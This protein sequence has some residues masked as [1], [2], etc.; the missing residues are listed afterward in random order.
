MENEKF[1]E[2]GSLEGSVKI[3]GKYIRRSGGLADII[4]EPVKKRKKKEIVID[5]QEYNAYLNDFANGI[6]T[7]TERVKKQMWELVT[8]IKEKVDY[9]KEKFGKTYTEIFKDIEPRVGLKY[10]TL[11]KYLQV[12]SFVRETAPG[13]VDKLSVTTVREI[14]TSPLPKEQKVEI[15]K[16]VIDHPIPR[17]EVSKRVK[18]TIKGTRKKENELPP[19][20]LILTLSNPHF[21][22]NVIG[23]MKHRM[24]QLE[25]IL[26]KPQK[27]DFNNDAVQYAMARAQA[28]LLGELLYRIKTM[29]GD[30]G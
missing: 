29:G 12:A 9:G 7:R 10:T 18:E 5:T 23:W 4:D 15:L 28:E 21:E 22:T 24:K 3:N 8:F 30:N 2:W 6:L 27:V 14:V 17:E 1:F 16:E 20:S 13:Q 19:D 26:E 25:K 11:L